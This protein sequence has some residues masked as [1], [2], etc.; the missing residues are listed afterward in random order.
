MRLLFISNLFPDSRELYRG[1][2]NVTILHGLADR[3]WSIRVLALRPSLPIFRRKSVPRAGDIRLSPRFVP[4]RYVPLYGSRVNH[5]LYSR[6]LR[7]ELSRLRGEFD[8]ALTSWIYPDSCAVSRIADFP[9]VSIAQGSDV[10]QYLRDRVRRRVITSHMP[11]AA[12]IITRSAD[13]GHQLAAAGID[14]AK[15]HPVYNGID[16]CNF[17]P[18]EPGEKAA[19]R[20]EF[21]IPENV[22][23][24]LF[25]GNFLP[26]KNPLIVVEGHRTLRANVP[27]AWLALI[28]GGPMEKEMRSRIRQNVKFVGRQASAEVARW[29]RA[30]DCLILPSV[31][32]GV[33][34]VILEAFASGL[35]VVASQVGGI[36]EVL[37]KNYGRLIQASEQNL[38]NA[39][40]EVLAEKIDPDKLATHGRSFTW[41]KTTLRYDEILRAASG[42]ISSETTG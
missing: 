4:V 3:G 31:N 17:R 37:N 18:P 11:K 42:T 27:Q 24:V 33:P 8:V 36:P 19:L 10:H 20:K 12:G 30:A 5:I 25:V 15:I 40:L 28:G 32:E 38:A 7:G 22:P 39:V 1:L 2:D 41:E 35:P 6:A 16:L 26:I 21:G 13:L 29:M 14:S 34:N 9:F 23:L